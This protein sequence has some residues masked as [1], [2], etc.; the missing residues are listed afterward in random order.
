MRTPSSEGADRDTRYPLLPG[1]SWIDLFAF[2][3]S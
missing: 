1:S 3:P 2:Y